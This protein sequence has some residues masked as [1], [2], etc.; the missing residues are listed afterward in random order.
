MRSLT[1]NPSATS[2]NATALIS[3]PP[4][5]AITQPITRW[6][7]LAS[8][9]IPAPRISAA[10]PTKPQNAASNMTAR[11]LVRTSRTGR[12]AP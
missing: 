4:P 10:P 3:T 6:D 8:R 5:K 1:S 7:G 12:G 9:P 11:T 2:S